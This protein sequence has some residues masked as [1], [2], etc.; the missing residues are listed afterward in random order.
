MWR[1]ATGIPIP[2]ASVRSD[3]T[4]ANPESFVVP[5]SPAPLATRSL[6]PV[7]VGIP[8]ETKLARRCHVANERRR[9]DDGRAREIS[10][11]AEAHP[12][13]PVPVEGG[14]R[15]LPRVEGVRPLAEARSA[16]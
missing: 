12:V 6:H 7:L 8:L 15:A 13:L 9:G 16:P 14:D 2:S 1:R 3:S 4:V 5:S 10:P 11:P